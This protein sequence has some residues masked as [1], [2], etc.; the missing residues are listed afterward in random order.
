MK[1]SISYVHAKFGV[2]SSIFG[3]QIAQKPRKHV[4]RFVEN[5]KKLFVFYR[6]FQKFRFLE[7]IWDQKLKILKIRDSH[8]VELGD[9]HTC[10]LF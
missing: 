3:P 5:F 6:F 8:F 10:W 2:N 7:K 9:L 1:T 4:F